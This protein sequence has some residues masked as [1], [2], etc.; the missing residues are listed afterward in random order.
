MR[1]KLVAAACGISVLAGCAG[2]HGFSLTPTSGDAMR[3]ASR[4]PLPVVMQIKVPKKPGHIHGIHPRYISAATQSMKV[5]ISGPT[6]VGQVVNLTPTSTGCTSTVASTLC[7]LT[8]SLA[9]G[10]YTGNVT[11]YDQTGAAGNT[12]STA[13]NIGFTVTA[14]QSNSINMVLSGV[15]AKLLV[16]PGG[17]SAATDASGTIDLVGT[18]HA[19]LLAEAL[20]A[21]NNIILG[22]GSPTFTI[23][24]PSGALTLTLTQPTAQSPNAFYV[25]PPGTYSSNT[26]TVKV[27]ASY[28]GQPTDGCAQTGAVCSATVNVAMTQL[29][30]VASTSSASVVYLTSGLS[31]T[32]TPASG[33]INAIAFDPSGNL[34]LSV[35]GTNC[36]STGSD[37]ILKYA[38]PYTGSPVS[39]TSSVVYPEG[40]AFD[41][42]GN[43]Y[44]ANDVRLAPPGGVG[45]DTVQEYTA[46][47]SASS[48]PSRTMTGMSQPTALAIDSNA[49]VFVASQLGNGGA[50]QVAGY[51]PTDNAVPTYG[52]ITSSV[53]GPIAIALD[54]SA[55]L[56]IL[57]SQPSPNVLSKYYGYTAVSAFGGTGAPYTC[58]GSGGTTCGSGMTTNPR[59]T[60]ACNVNPCTGWAPVS[61]AALASNN[62]AP[63][64]YELVVADHA[65]NAVYR[66]NNSTSTPAESQKLSTGVS[67][68]SAVVL[69]GADNLFVANQTGNNVVE[70]PFSAGAYNATPTTI[71]SSFTAP[72]SLALLP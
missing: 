9:P 36:G 5:I 7:V 23:S 15:P 45:T 44:V 25:Q 2:G 21:D 66:Y 18:S 41:S 61:I 51:K 69:D 59:T 46:P 11:T 70:F 62:S 34:Y 33:H 17:T 53:Q 26:A 57:N 39:I 20:D 55:N 27:Q 63:R 32:V 12:L 49:N 67:G 3:A 64:G 37:A 52:P 38:P 31:Q 58:N 19:K 40:I 16:L 50:G 24:Q 35:C 1:S 30:G 29:L 42:S 48:T 13:Q 56:Y 54:A 6:N 28:T 8:L 72:T 14:G 22:T 68:P 43:L 4:K 47:L 65:L 10:S 60:S 71:L